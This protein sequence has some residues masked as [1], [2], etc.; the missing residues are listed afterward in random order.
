MEAARQQSN[1]ENSRLSAYTPEEAYSNTT[2]PM[3]R[4]R[5]ATAGGEYYHGPSSAFLAGQIPSAPTFT[6][7]MHL[8]SNQFQFESLQHQSAGA[9]STAPYQPQIPTFSPSTST[10]YSS[11]RPVTAPSYYSQAPSF[12]SSFGYSQ[13]QQLASGHIVGA[14]STPVFPSM[15]G[16]RMSLPNTE[17][18]MPTPFGFSAGEGGFGVIQEEGA[19]YTNGG[20][21]SS[22]V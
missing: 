1:S 17:M 2:R 21:K 19:A 16:R 10:S 4:P 22:D 3:D 15:G 5:P 8:P 6:P 14:M 11:H 12:G 7:Q 9:Y 20:S 13:P 18:R